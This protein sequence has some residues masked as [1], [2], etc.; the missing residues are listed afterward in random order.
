MNLMAEAPNVTDRQRR[1]RWQFTLRS[2]FLLTLSVAVG[3]SFWKVDQDWY[4]GILFTISPWIVLGLAA[5]VRDI[6]SSSWQCE[7]P[8]CEDRWG[9]RFS[10]FWRLA[11]CGVMGLCFVTPFLVSFHLVTPSDSK[12]FIHVSSRDVARS[13]NHLDHR[14]G[15]QFAQIR[16][17]RSAACVVLGR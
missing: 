15:C 5:Q 9:R 12:E 8:T 3:L 1:G 16:P 17:T 11:L 7:N 13:S 6:W 2:L 10:I 4:D 14:C